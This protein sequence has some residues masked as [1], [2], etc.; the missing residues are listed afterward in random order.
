MKSSSL[1][2]RETFQMADLL[3]ACHKTH[4]I[5]V[6]RY[7]GSSIT[8][9]LSQSINIDKPI[10]WTDPLTLTIPF[11]IEGGDGAALVTNLT[12]WEIHSLLWLIFF[13]SKHCNR[14]LWSDF[15]MGNILILISFGESNLAQCAQCMG[16]RLW[17]AASNWLGCV[18]SNWFLIQRF[19]FVLCNC[20]HDFNL[21]HI[22][23]RDSYL[24]GRE[25]H[26]DQRSGG[27]HLTLGWSCEACTCRISASPAT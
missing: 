10:K 6:P 20:G 2:Q 9:S 14:N 21:I 25:W 15:K 3:K 11:H 5:E 7:L 23:H 17:W 24:P 8:M 22:A 26:R 4:T 16:L 13:T 1:N 27:S 18:L 19:Q 12:V